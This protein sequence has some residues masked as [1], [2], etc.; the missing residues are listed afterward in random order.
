M[1]VYVYMSMFV[2]WVFECML[3]VVRMVGGCEC[4]CELYTSKM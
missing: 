2:A 3:Y 1:Y 4:A